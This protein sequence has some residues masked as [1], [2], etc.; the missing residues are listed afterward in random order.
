MTLNAH[1]RDL[2]APFPPGFVATVTPEARPAVS[3]KGTFLV[4]DAETIAFGEIRSPGRR[5]I[6]VTAPRPR[7]TSS[8]SG[9]ARGCACAG[10]RGW[11]NRTRSSTVVPGA[12]AAPEARP[13]PTPSHDNGVSEAERIV[14]HKRKFAEIS[15]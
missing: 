8:T 4:L 7:S 5:A 6:P 1:A 3:A 9:R 15:T 12:G 13:V 14:P 2:I 10:R 11:W